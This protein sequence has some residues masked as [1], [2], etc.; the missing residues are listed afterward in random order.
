MLFLTNIKF[1]INKKSAYNL[2]Y[3][4]LLDMPRNWSFQFQDDGTRLFS[5]M[6]TFHNELMMYMIFLFILIFWFLVSINFQFAE[7]RSVNSTIFW[8]KAGEPKKYVNIMSCKKTISSIWKKKL[9]YK[10]HNTILEVTW[11]I[12]PTFFLIA[13]SI[14]S[15]LLIYLMNRPGGPTKQNLTIQ[16]IASQW[17]WSYTHEL[18]Q[19]CDIEGLDYSDSFDDTS[20]LGGFLPTDIDYTPRDLFYRLSAEDYATK[21]GITP[22]F[23]NIVF[24][25]ELKPTI[26]YNPADRRFRKIWHDFFFNCNAWGNL[27]VWSEPTSEPSSDG[28]IIEETSSIIR[29]DMRFFPAEAWNFKYGSYKVA[30]EFISEP[31][32]NKKVTIKSNLVE[33]YSLLKSDRNIRLLDVDRRLILPRN[34]EIRCL[35]TSTDVLHSWAIPSLGIKVDACPGRLNEVRLIIYRNSVFYGQC[36]EICGI[37]HGFMPIVIQSV[38][39]VDYLKYTLILSSRSI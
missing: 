35:V 18:Y 21:H 19:L 10:H 33:K 29:Y 14:P 9:I 28:G 34:V 22:P 38:C 23:D 39:L 7:S 16:I 12:L 2:Q 26:T 1:L 17:Y 36:S 11:T 30:T 3:N 24:P 8:T 20:E 6:K 25:F 27:R 5:L 32:R 31:L 4:F 13:V 37:M 15:L